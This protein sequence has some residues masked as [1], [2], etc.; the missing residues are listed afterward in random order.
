MFHKPRTEPFPQMA[1]DKE[2]QRSSTKRKGMKYRS[3]WLLILFIGAI[4]LCYTQFYT[5]EIGLV[6]AQRKNGTDQYV[7]YVCDGSFP[8]G[9]WADRQKGIVSAYV[10]AQMLGRKFR[11]RITTPCALSTHLAGNLQSWEITPKEL[12]GLSEKHVKEIDKNADSLRKKMSSLDLISEF[13]EDVVYFTSNM[14]YV[15]Y[16][17]KNPRYS[18]R[19]EWMRK[20]RVADVYTDTLKKLFKLKPNLERRLSNFTSRIPREKGVKLACAQVRLGKNP[21]VPTD[22]EQFNSFESVKA[23]WDFLK[24]YNDASKYRIFVTSDSE[25]V[26]KAAKTVFPKTIVD[27]EGNIVHVERT[28]GASVCDG[29]AKVILDQLILSTCDVLVISR[30]GLARIAAW[31]RGKKEDVYCFSKANVTPCNPYDLKAFIPSW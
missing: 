15:E 4:L 10:L 12:V 20:L 9:G 2:D 5:G 30:S 28:N 18:N 14:E 3:L 26:R 21:T 8:C 22:T 23:V 7:V 16:L 27:M 29:F 19:T 1:D 11:V 25:D 13:P 24:P 6:T 17:I 31:Y